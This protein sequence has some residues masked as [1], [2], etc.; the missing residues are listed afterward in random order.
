MFFICMDSLGMWC[1][2]SSSFRRLSVLPLCH[3]QPLFWERPPQSNGKMEQL[4]QELETSL[5]CF[6]SQNPAHNTLPSSATCL[7][8]FQCAYGY[9]P[10]LFLDL[11]T[12]V[13][14][15]S[16]LAF[17]HRVA[18]SGMG[19]VGCSLE[20]QAHYKKMAHHQRTPTPIYRPGLST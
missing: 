12:E 4:N 20:A 3:H 18:T 5:P 11:E 9:Q 15:S 7:S 6:V 1:R 19:Q 17:I 8:P 14:V 13:S 2:T 10:L 16:A